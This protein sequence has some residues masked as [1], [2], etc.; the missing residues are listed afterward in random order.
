MNITYYN[1][2]DE[3]YIFNDPGRARRPLI[4]VENGL[5]LLTREEHLDQV[6]KGKN[7]LE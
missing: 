5:P 6:E 1:D 3:I 4:I 2:T 7:H